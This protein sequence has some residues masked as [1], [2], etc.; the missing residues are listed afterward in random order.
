MLRPASKVPSPRS[1]LT[2]QQQMWATRTYAENLDWVPPSLTPVH[3]QESK[4][5]EP[6]YPFLTDRT[7]GASPYDRLDAN[8]SDAATTFRHSGWRST[9]ERVRVALEESDAPRS[10][11]LAFD[12]C[13]K[14][15][16]LLQSLS[17]PDHYKIAS[18]KCKDRFCKPCARERAGRVARNLLET[19]HDTK[20]RFIT[21]TLKTQTPDLRFELDRLYKAFQALRRRAFWKTH[22]TG[23]VALLEVKYNK[24][25]GRWHPHLHVLVTGG[26]VPR[27][28]LADEWRHVTG[29]SFIVDV[30]AV[31][32]NQRVTHYIC[33]YATDPIDRSI[34]GSVDLLTQAIDA[35]RGR[36][37]CLTFG[38]FRRVLLTEPADKAGWRHLGALNV[39]IT[40]AREGCQQSR[41]I[42]RSLWTYTESTEK[43]ARTPTGRSSPPPDPDLFSP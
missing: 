41:D 40:K 18:T 35:F 17:E 36:K 25:P 37:T 38:T 21:L 9:R 28:K 19:V 15:A 29:D 39:F 10:R 2:M 4:S 14:N 33:K 3:A 20:L 30:R 42:L 1:P 24:E 22:V 16:F 5:R 11:L 12:D 31:N 8:H 43:H 7:D 32:N 26:Y 13:G 34:G 23:G 27:T 6:A